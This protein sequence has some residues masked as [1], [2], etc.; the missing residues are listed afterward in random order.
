M[1]LCFGD[2][3]VVRETAAVKRSSS[4]GGEAKSR[5]QL[6]DEISAHVRERVAALKE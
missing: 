4:L 6:R 1:T 3:C 2:D 5:R